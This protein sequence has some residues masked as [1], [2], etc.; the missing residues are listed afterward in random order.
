M[1]RIYAQIG[2]EERCEIARLCASGRSI[3]QIATA[4]DRAPSTIAREVKRN[5]SQPS[6]YLP[7]YAS[8]QS[9]ARRWTG[10][11]LDRHPE[12][13]ES[14]IVGLATGLSPELVA[15]RD[16]PWRPVER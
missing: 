15:G 7:V 16:W 12:L 14:V 5:R 4:L 3:R 9:R 10:S 8:E 6:G 2:L 1:G 11:K 13:R